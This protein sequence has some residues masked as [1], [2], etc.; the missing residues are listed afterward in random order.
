MSNYQAYGDILLEHPCRSNRHA[1]LQ[2]LVD[3]SRGTTTS[4]L[5]LPA[6]AGSKTSQI[7][8][9]RAQACYELSPDDAPSS[10]RPS[11]SNTVARDEEADLPLRSLDRQNG[12][13]HDLGRQLNQYRSGFEVTILPLSQIEIGSM[14]L[15][16]VE[17][18]ETLDLTC[19]QD[20]IIQFSA[21]L[22]HDLGCEPLS[23]RQVLLRS[24]LDRVR[25]VAVIK[26][27]SAAVAAITVT[28]RLNSRGLALSKQP[29]SGSQNTVLTKL[30]SKTMHE[31]IS[32]IDVNHQV[33]RG[34]HRVSRPVQILRR[35][36]LDAPPKSINVIRGDTSL[37]G[38]PHMAP[39]TTAV[40]R[41]LCE[42]A[43]ER[44]PQ[45]SVMAS[46]TEWAD[47]NGWWAE[48]RTSQRPEH[49]IAYAVQRNQDRSTWQGLKF[50][51]MSGFHQ[52][53]T[54]AVR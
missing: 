32:D 1:R 51:L 49:R 9:S 29:W 34:D 2:S 11:I 5:H 23:D 39:S 24:E 48:T 13:P 30:K 20:R 16:A 54:E 8:A 6:V 4:A 46:I 3:S 36:C 25:A 40:D 47:V 44:P 33:S 45:H 28:L 19:T 35:M 37:P 12:V 52:F 38:P 27:V 26:I 53:T 41:L 31:N 10:S 14:L 43:E 50:I 21:S 42:V 18:E 15:D 17:S 7:T 22:L